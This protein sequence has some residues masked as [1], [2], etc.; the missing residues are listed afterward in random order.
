MMAR[1]A[2]VSGGPVF[3][4]LRVRAG[5]AVIPTRHGVIVEGGQRR[6]LLRGEAA[7]S[8]LPR[9]FPL[10]DGTR[11]RADVRSTLGL[12]DRQL[13][14]ALRPLLAE[15]LLVAAPARTTLHSGRGSVQAASYFD[16]NAEN[17][18]GR[19]G[20][21]DVS[22][23]LATA[24]VVLAGRAEPVRLAAADLRAS[25]VG[26]VSGAASPASVARTLHGHA[27]LHGRAEREGRLLVVHFEDT[28]QKD[29]GA[30][31][32]L[33]S[34]AEICATAGVPLLRC[35]LGPTHLTVG[36]LFISGY[37]A[38]VECLRRGERLQ[39][40]TAGSAS[41][42]ATSVGR[43]EEAV[44]ILAGMAV[45]ETLAFL[46]SA[47]SGI[48]RRL[49]RLALPDWSTESFDLVPDRDCRRCWGGRPPSDAAYAAEVCEWH[50]EPTPPEF[51]PATTP[52]P[53]E[54]G[55]LSA[56]RS[57]RTVF[58]AAPRRPRPR[59]GTQL[60]PGPTDTR[61]TAAAGALGVIMNRIAG[62]RDEADSS[63]QRAST[64][65]WAP[66]G[67]NLASVE[68]YA[69]TRPGFFDLPGTVFKYEDVG[70]QILA[71]RADEIGLPAVLHGTGL[72]P[73]TTDAVLVL[74]G[75]TARL[76]AKY[77]SF[78][79]RL[80]HLDAGCAVTQLALVAAEHEVAVRFAAGW[81]PG[82]GDLL[83]LEAGRQVV[84]AVAGIRF[85]SE[86]VSCL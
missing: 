51:T 18:G 31:D 8:I 43:S 75:A 3:T 36:P 33:A 20:I 73:D 45:A 7:A 81:D 80:A 10:L 6:R 77:E 64:R 82:L 40:E 22:A 21:G 32:D 62:Y 38:C 35:T 14:Q 15:G 78:A 48:R 61:P 28:E 13:D 71:L 56:L 41:E 83:E 37:T 25:G 63:G 42:D 1:S 66:S 26:H 54:T 85:G 4:D 84:T 72:D 39:I 65:R 17:Y 79:W 47:P 76:A 9:L 70:D 57:Q 19:P 58:P 53:A 68:V 50:A 74:T 67:G 59:P 12:T 69:I 49:V 23:G 86:V 11:E 2:E 30:P 29:D 44:G 5:L 60:Q 52:T 16:R 24:R 34:L 55:R 46:T 27:E